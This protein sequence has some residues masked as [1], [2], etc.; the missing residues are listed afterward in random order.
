MSKFASTM[1]KQAGTAA[2]AAGLSAGRQFSAGVAAGGSTS[3]AKTLVQELEV[4]SKRAA[5]V[6]QAEKVAIAKARSEEKAAA[7]GV[8]A[9]EARLAEQRKKYAASSSQAL[10]AEQQ[11]TSARGKQQ[12]AGMK[13]V[14]VE[15]Q[16][17]A[18]FNE[19]KTVTGQLS[20]AQGQASKQSALMTGRFSKLAAAGAPLSSGLGKIASGAKNVAATALAT[21]KPLAG[22]AAGFGAI[23]GVGNI[24]KLGNEYTATINELG[25][26][27]NA[28]AA[29]MKAFSAAT[30][31]LGSD[32]T[33][34]ATSG[35][36]AA[37]VM[38]ELAKGGLSAKQSIDA[39]KGT[40]LLAAA[41]QVD[42][43]QAAQ[44]QANALNQFGLSAKNASQVADVLANT[45]NAASGEITD[46]STALKYIGPVAN[47]MGISIGDTASAI[48]L[49]AKGGI[50]GDTAGTS[51]R[52]MLASLARPSKQAQKAVDAL[53]L[54]VFDQEG[55]FVG[56]R[57]VLESL[58]KARREMTQEDF[59]AQSV[60]AFG[61]EPLAAVNILAKAGAENFDA[62]ASAV[63]RQ[64]GAAAVAQSR[65]KGLGGAMDKLQS[66]LEDVALG[67]YQTVTPALEAAVNGIAGGLNGAGDKVQSF[68][69]IAGGL[70][71]LA[72]TGKVSAPISGIDPA[73]VSGVQTARTIIMGAFRD[74]WSFTTQSLIPSLKNIAVAVAPVAAVVGGIFVLGLRAAAA[75]LQLIGPLLVGV[76][77]FL[78][79]HKVIVGLAAGAVGFLVAAYWSMQV[80][81]G[82]I[83]AVTAATLIAKRAQDGFALASYGA[84]A[85]TQAQGLAG[86]A[87]VAVFGLW[88]GAVAIATAAQWAYNAALIANPIGLVVVAIVA[89]IAALAALVA[90]VV[91]AYKNLGWFKTAVDAVWTGIQVG[92]KAVGA[93]A[94]W[95]WKTV[96]VPALTGI[97]TAAMWV[98]N[99]VLKPVFSG[100]MTVVRAVGAVFTWWWQN[101]TMPVFRG[102][103][104]VAGWF[105]NTISAIFD[106]VI[107]M[108][109]F[110]LAPVFN[111]VA[112]VAKVAFAAIVAGIRWWWSLASTVFNIAVLF[113]RGTLGAAFTW[114]SSVV[115]IAFAAISAVTSAWWARVRVIFA[116]TNAYIR[117]TLGPVF[118]WLNRSIIAPAMTGIRVAVGVLWSW[119]KPV[120]D[121]LATVAKVTIP[122]AFGVMK[123]SIGK[124]WEAI[125]TAAKLPIRFVVETVINK[126]LIGNFNK[127]AGFFG[128]KKID[129]ISLPKGFA[130]GGII[131][132]R[133]R[134]RNGDDHLR[135]M[136]QGEGVLVS[137][138]LRT[139]ADRSAF[140]AANAAGRRGVGFASLLQGG[141]AKGGVVKKSSGSDGGNGNGL[142]SGAK[143]AWNWTKGAAGAAWDWT[144]NAAE[145]AS[146]V[147]S[148]PMGTLGKLVKSVIGNIP[149]AGGMV[150]AAAGMGNKLLSGAVSVL[151]NMGGAG[152]VGNFGGS[153]ANGQ[154]PK[155]ALSKVSGFTGGPGVGPIGGYLRKAAAVAWEAMQRA[156]GGG[157]SLTEG[158]RDLANQQMRYSA[159]RAGRG[160][161]AATPGTSVHGYGL[162]ADV[163]G[164]SQAWMRANG[165][166]FG[167][168]PTGLSFAQR[169]PWH[170]EYKGGKAAGGMAA[171]GIVGGL[172]PT[173][174]DKGGVLPQG[175]SLVQNNLRDPEVALPMQTLREIVSSEGGGGSTY[176]PVFHNADRGAIRQF[177][178]WMHR[179]EVLANG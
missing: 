8:Q 123:N 157:L 168:Y 40:I 142:L 88:R 48:G 177:E 5:K 11:L 47:A 136:R 14:A 81:P 38:L 58:A 108:V 73:V 76:T 65:M 174:Y 98:W 29:Q 35:R 144:K 41:A 106:L 166:R 147:V 12:T 52:G 103:A 118:T 155:S 111:S 100:I 125:K 53:N 121:K 60:L 96:F 114:V 143:A 92:A 30:R 50:L 23:I 173:L 2:K 26:V 171:G 3:A 69:K 119:L 93:A 149:G 19:Q 18:A 7:V 170:F 17:K 131:P 1:S 67:I 151:K 43:G 94:M 31:E 84:A 140:L 152:D 77:G 82:I 49:L 71:K 70:G 10:K 134:M 4:A 28:S 68:L 90:G 126:A 137:E 36:D 75:A 72:F 63:N 169:E 112:Q 122:A 101:V 42:G 141:Y 102:I 113:L 51:L 154:L 56:L 78:R 79:E 80:I 167:W 179:R 163:G 83:G 33:L 130:G 165:P 139:S 6:V 164:G 24:I 104:A 158:Y 128:T 15:D 87:G 44:I 107:A 97:G 57:A 153:G 176:A 25:A 89:A 105:G 32:L 13:V 74:I 129:P 39:A 61:R 159:Y 178:D 95:L 175:L 27:T 135:P 64:G 127:V 55:R 117:G 85:A 150:D 124:A 156:F 110:A 162:A 34:P 37:D 160:N 21:L 120:F 138:G 172:T 109:K 54:S 66:Q 115:R 99:T 46:M 9:A 45:A 91:W 20:A 22:M 16:L 148:D 59:A 132:G 116:A 145:T 62:M 146:Q 133:S 161:L 86:K